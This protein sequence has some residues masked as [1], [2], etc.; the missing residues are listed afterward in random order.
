MVA[1]PLAGRSGGVDR[2][3]A[4]MAFAEMASATMRR[5]GGR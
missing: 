1:M 5:E 4:A 3:L 2:L